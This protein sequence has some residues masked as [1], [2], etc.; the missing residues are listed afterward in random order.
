MSVTIS[1]ESPILVTGGSGYIASWI[2]RQ[3]LEK[4]HT[5]H[6]TVRSKSKTH[7]YAHLTKIAESAPGT[8]KIFE[9]DL[10]K[11]GSFAEGMAGCELVMHTASP[12][13]IRGIKNPQK[14]LVDP[15]LKGT[16]NVLDSVNA[17]D[18]VKRVVLTSSV[19]SI[20]G[21]NREIED[22]KEGKFTENHWNTTSS[23]KHQPYSYS[24]VLAEK[25]AWKI[26]DGQERWDMVVINPAF[27]LGPSLTE[28][29]N[30]ASLDFMKGILSGEMKMG[31]PD[32]SF[33]LVD[34]RDVAQAHLEAGYRADAAGRHITCGT[35]TAV[36][37]VE[38][39]K[40][41]KEK[42]GKNH[43]FPTRTLPK[44]MMYLVGPMA[45]FNWSGG[46]G[47]FG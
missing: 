13:V 5:V 40:V 31:A 35:E 4:G 3:L 6:A 30:S 39:G 22:K 42:F 15:A 25:E 47:T 18:S 23:L 41:L 43:P 34:V 20:Y 44:F 38:I 37:M 32:L 10:L 46:G 7:K 2:V 27:V 36:S 14:E 11:D 8:L 28:N 29:S 19:V 26:V 24:K 9:A 45:G 12:F 33:G 21:D 16:R 17:T 1:P